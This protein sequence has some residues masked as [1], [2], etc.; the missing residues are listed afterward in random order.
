MR[1]KIKNIANTVVEAEVS[2]LKNLLKILNY[3]I[4]EQIAILITQKSGKLIFSGVGKSGL[5]AKKISAMICSM[6]MQAVFLHSA[7]ACHGELGIITKND[8][9]FIFSNSGEGDEIENVINFCKMFSNKI[10]AVTGNNN[11]YLAKNSDFSIMLPQFNELAGDIPLISSMLMSSFGDILILM[12]K[13]LLNISNDDFLL[14][15]PSGKIGRK[16]AK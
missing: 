10:V 9:I 5:V 12:I 6:G 14:N 2:E 11:A 13:E 7:E 3:E 8:L 4:L 15:H 16:L 1:E